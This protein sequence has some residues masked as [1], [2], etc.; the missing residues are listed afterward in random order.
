MS[1]ACCLN[2]AMRLLQ[3][4][5]LCGYRSIDESKLTLDISDFLKQLVEVSQALSEGEGQLARAWYKLA[6]LYEKKGMLAES[7]QCKADAL[8]LRNKLRVQDADMPFEEDSF[9]K[10]CL[11]MLW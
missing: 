7:D 1:Q 8:R 2:E 6:V 11:W 3:R 4:R 9:M 5:L 10:L